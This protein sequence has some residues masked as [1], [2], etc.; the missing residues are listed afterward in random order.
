M[1]EDK[2]SRQ[3]SSCSVRFV[4]SEAFAAEPVCLAVVF[5]TPKLCLNNLDTKAPFDSSDNA[6]SH[7]SLHV[8][9]DQSGLKAKHPCGEQ[10]GKL[11]FGKTW[12]G[13]IG[14]SIVSSSIHLLAPIQPLGPW[15]NVM[16]E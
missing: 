15:E 13:L 9:V 12:I 16:F 7:I 2:G 3:I 1:I 14:S 4:T 8:G 10:A 11:G 6:T 5:K